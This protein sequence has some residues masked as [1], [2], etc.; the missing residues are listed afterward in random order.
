MILQALIIEDNFE[1]NAVLADILLMLGIQV[2]TARDGSVALKKLKG[3]VPD[4]VLLD[5]HI[6][7]ISGQ[8]LLNQIRGDKRFQNT[9]VL[10]LTADVLLAKAIRNQADAALTKPIGIEQLQD[11]IFQLLPE[12]NS[13]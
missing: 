5:M 4:L 9:K 11:A 12:S 1:L 6:P 8:E 7:N 10:V 13:Q 2:D 3:T